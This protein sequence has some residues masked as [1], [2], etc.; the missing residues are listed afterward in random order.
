[1]MALMPIPTTFKC[2][3]ISLPEATGRQDHM[4]AQLKSQA[5]D[6]EF[7]DAVDGRGFDVPTH[8]IY[9][10]SLRRA[11]FG[12]DLKGGE[13]GVLLSHK[14]IFEKML[15]DNIDQALVFEDDAILES[16]FKSVL[17]DLLNG[18]QDYDL[19][20]FL[21]SDKVARI[22]QFTVRP[23]NDRYTL[24]CLRTAPGGAFAYVITRAGA[25]KMLQLLTR[26]YLPID[27]LM[28]HNW[29]NGLQAYIIQPGLAEQDPAQEQYIGTARFKKTLDLSGPMRFLF[30]VT[31]AAYKAYEGLCKLAYYRKRQQ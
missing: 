29:K 17:D 28:G 19:V 9:N 24:N 26:I 21:G 30:P 10:A 27:T 12:R 3:V 22:E 6:F 2:F 18:P 15:H 14:A 1:M 16:D 13:L 4:R 11:F 23:V 31:R 5:I 20:R 25:E 7:F 8:P